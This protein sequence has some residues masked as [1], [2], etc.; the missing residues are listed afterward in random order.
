MGNSLFR[1]QVHVR[2]TFK[3]GTVRVPGTKTLIGGTVLYDY[4]TC[5][6]IILSIPMFLNVQYIGN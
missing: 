6:I 5:I 1:V 2:C 3:P 4:S